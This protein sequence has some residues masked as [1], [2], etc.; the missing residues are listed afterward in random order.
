MKTRSTSKLTGAVGAFTAIAGALLLAAI[1]IPADPLGRLVGALIGASF[2]AGLAGTVVRESLARRRH[3]DRVAARQLVL[4]RYTP[5]PVVAALPV[6]LDATASEFD[7]DH[8][9]A[10]A[11][12]VSLTEAQVERRRAER[13]R[14]HRYAALT[15][16]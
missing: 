9:S 7:D 2:M 10:F 5:E 12:V 13:E 15:R 6:V 11:P 14:Q 16:A 3:V 1:V 8:P 4:E